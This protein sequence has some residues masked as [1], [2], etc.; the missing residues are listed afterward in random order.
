MAKVFSLFSFFLFIYLKLKS[1]LYKGFQ[2]YRSGIYDG[3][4]CRGIEINHAVAIVGYGSEGGKDFWKIRNSW[5]PGW[6][7]NG[8]GRILRNKGN[9]CGIA[10]DVWCI[11]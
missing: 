4:E 2:Y 3:V 11:A 7:E 1:S 8:N 10:A 9:V 6:G 5:G